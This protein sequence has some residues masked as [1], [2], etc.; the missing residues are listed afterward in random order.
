MDMCFD[1]VKIGNFF[2]NNKV[3]NFRELFVDYKL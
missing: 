3:E 1:K 2:K